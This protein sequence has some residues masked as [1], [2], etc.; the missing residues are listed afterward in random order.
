M[1]A[2]LACHP[3][4][5]PPCP[6]QLIRRQPVHTAHAK[7]R[8]SLTSVGTQSAYGGVAVAD[9]DGDG[10]AEGVGDDDAEHATPEFRMCVES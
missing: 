4:P 1:H 7:V 5:S 8:S 10:A 3:P 9:G 6:A 2:Q